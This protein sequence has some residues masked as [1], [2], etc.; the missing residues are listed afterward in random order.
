M[1]ITCFKNEEIVK[2][3]KICDAFLGPGFRILVDT[4]RYGVTNNAV[5]DSDGN[6]DRIFATRE[7]A[8]DF[9]FNVI[10]KY[11]LIGFAD[12]YTVYYR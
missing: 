3:Y 2:R 12:R 9:V 6:S 7:L 11:M 5:V 10:D 1:E 8:S 4:P